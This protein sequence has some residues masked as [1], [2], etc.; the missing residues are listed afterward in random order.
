MCQERTVTVMYFCYLWVIIII[1]LHCRICW[2]CESGHDMLSKQPVTDTFYDPRIQ[3][4][5]LQVRMCKFVYQLNW[6]CSYA[7]YQSIQ[8]VSCISMP[9]FGTS[10]C[11]SWF[12]R[13]P[14]SSLPFPSKKMWWSN[15]AFH[16]QCIAMVSWSEEL[17]LYLHCYNLLWFPSFTSPDMSVN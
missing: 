9:D 16:V 11:R 10:I 14:L 3:E 12:N 4:C 15:V 6:C 5:Y 1:V 2:S 8:S 7:S 13:V 17:V